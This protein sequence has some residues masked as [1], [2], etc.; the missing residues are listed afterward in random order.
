MV[1]VVNAIFNQRN[2]LNMLISYLLRTS[3]RMERGEI[4]TKK[5]E[6]KYD[7]LHLTTSN[8]SRGK[9]VCKNQVSFHVD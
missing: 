8:H 7:F 5:V 3:M 6:F 4:N 9:V 1:T 2:Y